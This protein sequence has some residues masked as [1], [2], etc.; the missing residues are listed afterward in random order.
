[1]EITKGKVVMVNAKE[2]YENLLSDVYTWLMGGFSEA[3]RTNLDFFNSRNIVPKSSGAALDLG[4]GS[5][6]Q[7]I[8]LS[9]L[10]FT[11][12]AID[13][14]KKLLH[15]LKANAS[16][17]PIVS[18]NDDI[19][20]LKKYVKNNCELIIC[21]TDTLTH[22][23]SKEDVT[24][25]FQDSY[26]SLEINGKLIL[27][28]RDLTREL[29]DTDRFIPVRSDDNIIFTCFLEY[30]PETVKIHDIVYTKTND[31]WKLNKSC[32][33]KIRLSVDWV[34][35]QLLA[36]GFKLAESTDSNGFKTIVAVK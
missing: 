9:E 31:G 4:A 24:K 14:S 33:R 3:K 20:N 25:I 12:T 36:V 27:T 11:V 16:D 29:V 7:S 8:P 23:K 32:Y 19:L 21:M 17:I 5:G 26:A 10:G 6:F 22:L 35:E 13:L 30:E 18:I 2:H 15:E 28:F 1:L 34:E